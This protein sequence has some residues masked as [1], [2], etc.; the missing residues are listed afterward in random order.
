MKGNKFGQCANFWVYLKF[1]FLM[2]YKS[3]YGG[4]GRRDGFKI[5]C[6]SEHVRSSRTRGT[7]QLKI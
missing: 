1:K 4:I 7:N 5:R 3:P 6:S 2:K